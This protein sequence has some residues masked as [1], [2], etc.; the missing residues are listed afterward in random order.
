MAGE[1]THAER[2]LTIRNHLGMHARAAIKLVKLANHF[3]SEI[4]MRKDGQTVNGKSIMGILSLAAGLG[5]TV[6]VV[7]D[8]L[9]AEQ[10]VSFL[11]A[12]I[13]CGFGEGVER[14]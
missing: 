13:E 1:A 6:T 8:G 7:A 2:D 12:L 3:S 11:A 9:D 4:R 14:A 10:A 5:D